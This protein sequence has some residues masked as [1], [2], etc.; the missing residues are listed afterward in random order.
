M[1]HNAIFT[2]QEM[3]NDA[4]SAEKQLITAYGIYLAEASCENLRS[5][6]TRIITEKQ[7][8][9]YQ[10]FDAIR[11]KGWYNVKNA[12]IN[13]VQTAVQKFQ[14]MQQQMQQQ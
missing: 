13:D 4:L 3:M 14:G 8:I 5:Q 11:Q 1:P 6:L 9:Q 7:Q 12:N 2:E 10:I